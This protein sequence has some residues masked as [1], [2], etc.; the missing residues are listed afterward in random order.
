ME[1][2]R[3]GNLGVHR[4][5]RNSGHEKIL[6]RVKYCSVLYRNF[7]DVNKTAVQREGDA[8]IQAEQT[9]KS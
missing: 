3:E 7:G 5:R 1:G 9:A 6:P 4:E 2:K 8:V